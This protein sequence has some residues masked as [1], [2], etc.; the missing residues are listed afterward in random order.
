M[1][2]LAFYGIYDE[3][4]VRFEKYVILAWQWGSGIAPHPVTLCPLP[5]VRPTKHLFQ[6]GEHLGYI[7]SNDAYDLDGCR[8]TQPALE[9]DFKEQCEEMLLDWK[10]DHGALTKSV[11]PDA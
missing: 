3:G 9:R 8:T 1:T 10:R 7:I 6:V 5:T 11:M 2:A 4:K